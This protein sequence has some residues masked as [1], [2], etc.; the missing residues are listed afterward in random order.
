MDPKTFMD[1]AVV[2][3]K[4][5]MFPYF[6]IA[7]YALM[8]MAVRDD[9]PQVQGHQQS[10][11]PF[12]RKHPL[13]TWVSCMLTCFAG[14]IIANVLLGEPAIAP[15]KDHKNLMV[16][17][18]VW[19]LVFYSPFDIVYKLAKKLPFKATLSVLKEVQRAH[20]VYHGV[21]QTAKIYPSSYFI[22]VTIGTLKGCGSAIMKN[23]ERMIRGL[24]LPGSNEFL[25]PSFT[26]K[27]S[28]VASLVF[29]LERLN[30]I[31]VPHPLIYFSV[32]IFF[33]YFKLSSIILG[34]RDPFSPFENLFCAIFM[35][36]MWDAMRRAVSKEPKKDDESKDL[37]ND[38][39]KTK[40]EKKKD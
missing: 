39:L 27:A 22:I 24:W 6:D 8:C 10:A 5:K 3:T 19:Y 2:I 26:A 36:G 37:R 16:A 15:F 1:I 12:Y 31:S 33:I 11:Q 32:V 30:Y 14:G 29:L 9:M 17:S 23:F 25:Q 38:L 20:K 40:E 13:S 21:L 28:L 34:I 35:G 18:I 7:H 4:L